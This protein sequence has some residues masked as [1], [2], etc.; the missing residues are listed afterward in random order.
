MKT[1]IMLVR[2]EFWEHRSLWLTPVFT[3]VVLILLSAVGSSYGNG[4]AVHIE[5]NGQEQ[6]FLDS[7]TPEKRTTMFGILIGGLLVPQLIVMLIVL[8]FYVLDCLY[9]ERKDRSILFW[10]SLPVSDAQTVGSKFLTAVLVVPLLVYGI[11]VVTSLVCYVFV[12]LRFSSGPFAGFAPWDTLMWLKTQ[13]ILL[14]D[15][16]IAALWYAP[17]VAVLLLASAWVRRNLYTW[18]LLAPLVVWFVE[19]RAF[20]TDYFWRLLSYRTVG[21]FQA[22]GVTQRHAGMHEIAEVYAR[23]DATRLLASPDLWLGVVVALGLLYATARIRRYRD[24][25]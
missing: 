16:F 1:M 22:L 7:L 5:V 4:A 23:F 24:D 8:S 12:A 17:L 2:R 3:A 18:V 19:R 9:S 25:T 6:A 10:K 13:A 15:T 11:S 20:G 21:F 14:A